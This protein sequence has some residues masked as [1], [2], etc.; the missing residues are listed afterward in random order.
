[1][2]ATGTRRLPR[3]LRGFAIALSLVLL[4]APV[5]TP[6]DPPASRGKGK[7]K[8]P[9]T[10]AEAMETVKAWLEGAAKEAGAKGD[11]LAAHV[12]SA[13]RA[14]LG[15]GE[16][17]PLPKDDPA[18]KDAEWLERSLAPVLPAV[19]L[20]TTQET[21]PEVVAGQMVR[22]LPDVVQTL[23]QLNGHRRSAA[24]APLAF[25]AGKSRGCV[26]HARYLIKTGYEEVRKKVGTPHE[27]VVGER[28]STPEGLQAGREACLGQV[29]LPQGVEN[30]IQTY[31]HRPVLLHPA[32]RGVGMGWWSEGGMDSY[33]IRPANDYDPT[34]AGDLTV[35]YPGPDA[36]EV[37]REFA[38][39]GERP[40]PVPGVDST[41]HGNPI[42]VSFYANRRGVKDFQ[43]E[44]FAGKRRVEGWPSSPEKPSNPNAVG[45]FHDLTAGFIPATPFASGT[46]FEVRARCVL[47]GAPWEKTWT[48]VTR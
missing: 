24:V 19:D 8:P 18:P 20:L 44:V 11:P 5:A 47:G 23:R 30:C 41:T 42:T 34:Y 4:G 9:K 28:W 25:H 39:G 12:I 14:D 29:R 46:R 32:E 33:G 1:M 35:V 2:A 45:K 15:A 10:A 27:E 3:A 43:I 48:F 21:L 17:L 38:L 31:Y 16:A 37:K 40:E 7:P 6:K 13:V 22:Q 26:L 36:K